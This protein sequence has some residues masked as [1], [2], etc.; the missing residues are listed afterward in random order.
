MSPTKRREFTISEQNRK[1][2]EL[3][4]EI[5]ALGLA[6]RNSREETLEE[7]AIRIDCLAEDTLPAPEDLT[8]I[9]FGVAL[10]FSLV[11]DELKDMAAGKPHRS[12]D[13]IEKEFFDE[14]RDK[15]AQARGKDSPK[16]PSG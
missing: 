14:L 7:V 6:R 3:T 4:N 2:L 12:I 5:S 11:R 13:Q 16:P 9:G 8:S 15:M 10:A 1:I